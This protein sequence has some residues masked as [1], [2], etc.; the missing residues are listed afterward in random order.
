[1]RQSSMFS[2]M[3][4]STLALTALTGCDAL[5][6]GQKNTEAQDGARSGESPTAT[7]SDVLVTV[8]GVPI[9]VNDLHYILAQEDKGRGKGV[10]DKRAKEV[11]EEIIDKE[12]ARQRA[13]ALGLAADADYQRKL[14]FMQAPV[15]DFKRKELAKLQFQKEVT[16]KAT[17]DEAEARKDFEANRA[18][19]QTESH[20]AQILVRNNDDKIRKL[21]KELDAGK[22]FDD[23]AA[24]LFQPNLPPGQRSPWDLG[25]LRW[26][27][28]PP[29][30][31]DT[32]AGMKEGDVSEILQGPNGRTW[33]IK[34]VKRNN[35][36]SL[37]FEDMKP[38]LIKSLQAAKAAKLSSG[39]KEHLRS[40]AAIVYVRQP[41]AM[42]PP[43]ETDE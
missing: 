32:L 29:L 18:R 2:T 13:E 4:A 16:E 14:R 43:P 3:L 40:K 25:L 20:V 42:P 28:M 15:D 35:N 33:I 36:A 37:T 22:P 12:L 38:E 24:T 17:V 30:W 34:L 6:S 10:G 23:V 1:M 5:S 9:G 39:A 41:G 8:N 21:K 31:N 27:Q 7:P 26:H 11:L 19:Y